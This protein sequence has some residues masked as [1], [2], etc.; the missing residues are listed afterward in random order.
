[1]A[2]TDTFTTITTGNSNLPSPTVSLNSDGTVTGSEGSPPSVNINT[3]VV[4]QE[5]KLYIEG[6]QVPFQSISVSQAIGT[7]PSATISVP[8]QSGLM[9][10]SR[11]YQPKVHIFYTDLNTGGDRLLFWGHINTVNY[12]RSRSPASTYI[13]F[14]CVHKNSLMRLI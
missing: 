11:Y 3:D 4:Y 12:R 10:I 7:Y 6:V 5:I 1:M 9:H 13:E 14:S 8:P 2:S